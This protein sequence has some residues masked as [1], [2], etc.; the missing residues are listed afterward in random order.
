MSFLNR[1]KMKYV[2]AA[3]GGAYAH[4]EKGVTA[5]KTMD[6]LMYHL[7]RDDVSDD[8]K[9]QT[10]LQT[11]ESYASEQGLESAYMVDFARKLSGLAKALSA[12]FSSTETPAEEP[13][14]EKET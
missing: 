14:T 5:E 9:K 1:V 11:V 12:H 2:A 6:S 8:K 13:E 3:P 4:H 10:M 7:M